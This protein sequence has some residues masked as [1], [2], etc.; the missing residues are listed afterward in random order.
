MRQVRRS[1]R[2]LPP[3]PD[4]VIDDGQI[5]RTGHHG[6]SLSVNCLRRWQYPRTL[7][8]G[9]QLSAACD[10]FKTAYAPSLPVRP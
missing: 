8:G 1:V 5:S 7:P 2:Y 9:R 6:A 3:Y 4:G 10:E